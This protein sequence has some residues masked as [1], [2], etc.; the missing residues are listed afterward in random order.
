MEPLDYAALF[1]EALSKALAAHS[2]VVRGAHFDLACFY[3]RKLAEPTRLG[4]F[5]NP[6]SNMRAPS[7][8]A[9]RGA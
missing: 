2:E 6:L 1:R 7:G 8:R 9:R 4:A 5:P 3:H